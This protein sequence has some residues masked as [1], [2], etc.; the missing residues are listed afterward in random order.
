MGTAEW[1]LVI[2]IL[3]LVAAV[4]IGSLQTWF[5]KRKLDL[6]WQQVAL[7]ARVVELEEESKAHSGKPTL[8]A[9]I[10][11]RPLYRHDGPCLVVENLAAVKAVNVR[12]FLDRKTASKHGIVEK[13]SDSI[14]EIGPRSET[15]LVLKENCQVNEPRHVRVTWEDENSTPYNFETTV[16]F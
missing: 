1:A 13:G 9:K 15:Y 3:S 2:S 12:V 10:E 5:R 4:I 6:Q 14:P 16:M 11:N 8:R 7:Q